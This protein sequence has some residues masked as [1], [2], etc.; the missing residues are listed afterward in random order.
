MK[1][2]EDLTSVRILSERIK[3]L[4]DVIFL[5]GDN[6]GCLTVLE[7][8]VITDE[9]CIAELVDDADKR[10]FEGIMVRKN[11]VYEGKRSYNLLKV[12]K[13][14]D[15]E[16]KVV[17]VEIN[18]SYRIVKD[19]KEIEEPLLAKAV[20]IHKGTEVGVGSGWSQDQRRNFYHNPDLLIG[21]TITVQ[22]FEETKNSKTG[23]YSLRFPVVKHI[24]DALRDI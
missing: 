21:R 5:G 8:V 15:A 2:F 12:K 4:K 6:S 16:Y 7:Q 3:F 24:W 22:Y 20:I 13:F 19:G 23:K 9:A 10:G 11:T 1:E 14:H 17:G 18:E